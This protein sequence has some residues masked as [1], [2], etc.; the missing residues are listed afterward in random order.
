MCL[1]HRVRYLS[2]SFL[3]C[4]QLFRRGYT[5]VI[6]IPSSI[7]TSAICQP[8]SLIVAIYLQ[9]NDDGAIAMS[10]TSEYGMI[11]LYLVIHSPAAYPSLYLQIPVAIKTTP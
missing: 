11:L 5:L 4:R 7:K 9:S 10:R 8:C 1:C 6:E 3:Q 2:A